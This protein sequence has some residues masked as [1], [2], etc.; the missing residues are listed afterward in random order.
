MHL[1]DVADLARHLPGDSAVAQDIEPLYEWAPLSTSSIVAAVNELRLLRHD[2]SQFL[3]GKYKPELL[4]P[5]GVSGL[6]DGDTEVDQIGANEGFDSFAE[7]DSWYRERF[8][9]AHI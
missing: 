4:L 6:E 9:D 7:A 5:E 8:P 1:L 2:L 3:G